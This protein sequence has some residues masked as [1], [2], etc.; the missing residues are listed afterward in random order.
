MKSF[1]MK[2]KS[3]PNFNFYVCDLEEANNN[4]IFFSMIAML[5]EY[6]GKQASE[7]TTKALAVKKA[8]LAKEGKK[9]GNPNIKNIATKESVKKGSAKSAKVRTIKADARAQRFLEP[10]K[11]FMNNLN[12]EKFTIR[13]FGEMLESRGYKTAT[14]KTVWRHEQ[15]KQLVAKLEKFKAIEEYTNTTLRG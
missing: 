15:V 14:G 4:H 2:M 8:K 1:L 7:R 5:A 11:R 12:N 9:L 6:E 10:Y 3:N 13:K